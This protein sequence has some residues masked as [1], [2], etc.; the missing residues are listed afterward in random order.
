M[1]IKLSEK[2]YLNSDPYCYWVTEVV[3]P[4]EKSRTQKPY[5]RR[6]S[7][8]NGTFEQAVDSYIDRRIRSLEIEEFHALAK[9]LKELKEEIRGW[10]PA[11]ERRD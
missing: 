4:T 9:E 6:V 5:E 8:Y 11:V 7:G 2:Y 10:Q 1:R 3:Q